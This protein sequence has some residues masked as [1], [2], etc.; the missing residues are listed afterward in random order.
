M[1]GPDPVLV[2]AVS[3]PVRTR[4]FFLGALTPAQRSGFV[5]DA[6]A[7]LEDYVERTRADLAKRDAGPGSF[8]HLAALG[9]VYEAE[10]RVAWMKELLARMDDPSG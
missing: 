8:D 9:A 7:A 4:V 3:D 6:L 2:S 10:A 1:R 5:R